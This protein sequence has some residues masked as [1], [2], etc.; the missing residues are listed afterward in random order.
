[1][2]AFFFNLRTLFEKFPKL[3]LRI[4]FYSILKNPRI[5][6]TRFLKPIFNDFAFFVKKNN[7][8]HFHYKPK[9]IS[10]SFKR[11]VNYFSHYK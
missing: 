8:M 6:S 5:S 1:M 4:F 9:N 10:V 3:H 11:Y 7:K 2:N